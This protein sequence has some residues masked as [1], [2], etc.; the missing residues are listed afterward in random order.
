[1]TKSPEKIARLAIDITDYI[2]AARAENMPLISE[3]IGFSDD[4]YETLEILKFEKDIDSLEDFEAYSNWEVFYDLFKDVNGVSP[5]WT[6]WIDHDAPSW[7]EKIEHLS[8]CL[9]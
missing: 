1:M 3:K 2:R 4:L 8:S 7:R 5:R 6:R 9:D